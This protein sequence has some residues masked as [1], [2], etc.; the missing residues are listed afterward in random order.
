MKC[1]VLEITK[2]RGKAG[3][4]RKRKW[5]QSP[6]LGLEPHG[7]DVNPAEERNL[8]QSR[9][10]ISKEDSAFGQIFINI[11]NAAWCFTFI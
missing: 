11:A 7:M 4:R 8:K 9:K 6:I 2:N 1:G 3:R 5:E 10:L